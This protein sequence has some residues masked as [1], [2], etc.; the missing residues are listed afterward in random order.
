MRE[1]ELALLTSAQLRRSE[2]EYFCSQFVKACGPPDSYF[3]MIS[4]F[5]AFLFTLVSIEEIVDDSRKV[6]LRANDTFR[7]VKALRNVTAHHS[8]L[9]SSQ[10]DSKFVRPLRRELK[11]GVGIS[12]IDEGKL[13]I[14]FVRFR[15]I[16]DAVQ[17]ERPGERHT[18]DAARK[19]LDHLETQPQPIYIEHVLHHV[20]SEVA[21]IVA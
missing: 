7:F 1:E 16:F 6:A 19:Y 12:G 3:R 5:D 21:Q 10:P 4:Y 2:A 8:I 15:E 9:A 17:A 18:L 13:S 20:L 11:V 14:N